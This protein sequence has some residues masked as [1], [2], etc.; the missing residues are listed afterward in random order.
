[1]ETYHFSVEKT[2]RQTVKISNVEL[3]AKLSW[4]HPHPLPTAERL[5]PGVTIHSHCEM[6][7]YIKTSN[8]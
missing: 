8:I 1:M 5:R 2:D 3:V 6:V 7:Q 4:D